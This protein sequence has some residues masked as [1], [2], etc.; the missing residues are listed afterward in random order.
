MND[1]SN[2]DI[3]FIEGTT[4]DYQDLYKTSKFCLSPHGE[5]TP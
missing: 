4:A 3:V 5:A 2:S 1:T